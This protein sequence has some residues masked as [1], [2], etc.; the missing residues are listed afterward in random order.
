MRSPHT[1]FC[2]TNSLVRD[3]LIRLAEGHS[4]TIDG[5]RRT[6]FLP[7]Q[8]RAARFSQH[9]IAATCPPNEETNFHREG[10]AR[11][12]SPL[13]VLEVSFPFHDIHRAI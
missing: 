5:T 13:R 3:S 9:A 11:P 6:P 10:R 12:G 8:T 4:L 7:K 1:H 2:Q